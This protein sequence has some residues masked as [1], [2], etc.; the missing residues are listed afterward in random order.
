MNRKEISVCLK[1]DISELVEIAHHNAKTPKEYNKIC[2]LRECIYAGLGDYEES[3]RE[4]VNR[5][6]SD[7]QIEMREE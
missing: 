1:Q 2:E 5:I 6:A 7:I 3:W 4:E